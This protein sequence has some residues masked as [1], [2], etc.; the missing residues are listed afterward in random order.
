MSEQT[1]KCP[2]CGTAIDLDQALSSQIGSDIEAKL[3]QEFNQRFTDEVSKREA[4]I[5]KEQAEE[6]SIQLRDLQEQLSQ[7]S[8]K[9]K[10]SQAK[11]L[12]FLRR[13]RELEE[14]EHSLKLDMEREQN[15]IRNEIADKMAEEHRMKDA[16][17]ERAMSDLRR[18]IEELN[19]RA[20]QGSQQSQGE[21]MELELENLL[22]STFPIDN[23][24][25]VAKG[26]RGAD[27]MQRVYTK[28]GQDCGTIL[29]E[30][31]RTKN[32]TEGWIPK[33]KDDQREAKANVA[34][35][36]SAVLPKD[37]RYIGNIDGVW[38]SDFAAAMGLASVIRAGIIEVAQTRN[39]MV[40]KNEKME[41][42]YNYLSGQEF[43]QRI[44]GIVESFTAM[45]IDLDAEKRAMDKIWQKREK[46]IERVIHNTSCMY[47]QLEG[48]MGN[49]L[50]QVQT[51]ELTSA[52]N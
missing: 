6:L 45:K 28:T 3:R 2:S 1:I 12:E 43:R 16:E 14:R 37:M 42:L 33:L 31:K 9:L 22:R 4:K 39:A 51:L 47:G 19:R 23:I 41:S 5:K 30:S 8:D 15:K 52:T 40:G 17:K 29:W 48:I 25:P 13:Q 24:E 36:V 32:W 18:Q 49:A 44:E 20:E 35:I 26:V 34:I 7:K 46:Q 11:E 10:D 50:P 27:V 38:V 21:I